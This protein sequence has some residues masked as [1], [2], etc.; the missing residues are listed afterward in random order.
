MGKSRQAGAKQLMTMTTMPDF[1]TCC[2]FAAHQQSL[3][4]RPFLS[5][6]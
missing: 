1:V 4:T 5:R 6:A 3:T 2:L